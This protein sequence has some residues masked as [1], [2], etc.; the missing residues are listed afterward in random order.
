[1]TVVDVVVVVALVVV[2]VAVDVDVVIRKADNTNRSAV[3]L[4][5]LCLFPSQRATEEEGMT[6][7]ST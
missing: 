6:K 5:N 4:Y 1:M 2:V 3:T 7:T